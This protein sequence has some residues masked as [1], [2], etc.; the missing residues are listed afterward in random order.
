MQ[1]MQIKIF[2][3]CKALK[4]DVDFDAMVTKWVQFFYQSDVME[5][6]GKLYSLAFQRA[7]L[8]FCMTSEAGVMANLKIPEYSG[9]VAE[10]I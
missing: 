9:L 3:T 5:F 6:V 8:H 2:E 4:G 1:D 7:P 10:N